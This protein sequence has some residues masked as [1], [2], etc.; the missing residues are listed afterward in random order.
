MYKFALIATLFMLT[1]SSHVITAQNKIKWH[2][3]EEAIE[4]SKKNKKK[5]VVDIYTEWCGWCK[6]MDKITFAQ[7]D[8]AKYIN[9]NYYA[10]KFDAEMQTPIILKG[11][12][13]K[14][15]KSGNRGYHELA[16]FLLQGRMSY[17]TVVFLD[18]EFNIIQAIPGFQDEQTFEMIITYFETNSHKSIPWNKY[19]QNFNRNAYFEK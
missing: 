8:I 10:V 7:M 2:T 3:W 4:K 12:E 18:E 15:V 11:T 16:A 14:F 5:I 17:P 9:E 19:M 6:K 13:Y 1:T